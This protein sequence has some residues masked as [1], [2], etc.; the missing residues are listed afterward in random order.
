MNDEL[1]IGMLQL[2]FDMRDAYDEGMIIDSNYEEA[3]R[4]A[5]IYDNEGE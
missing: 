3:N 1:F 2:I 5:T 4:L